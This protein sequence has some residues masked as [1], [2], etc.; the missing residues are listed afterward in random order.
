MLALGL[1]CTVL[2]ACSGCGLWVSSNRA[3]NSGDLRLVDPYDGSRVYP[4]HVALL[5]SE[6]KVAKLAPPLRLLESRMAEDSWQYGVIRAADCGILACY[7]NEMDIAARALD[8]ALELSEA[9]AADESQTSRVRGTGG[10]ER[11]KAFAGEPHETAA[12][13]I[14]RGLVYLAKNDPENAKSCFLQ[15]TLADAMSTQD[16]MRSNWLTADILT[17][18]SFRLYGSDVRADDHIKMIAATYSDTYDDAG[19]V[20]TESLARLGAKGLT[21]VVVCAGSPP[22]KYGQGQLMYEAAESKVASV[23]VEGCP[24]WLTDSVYIQAVTRGRRNVDDMIR[25]RERSRQHLQGIGS[26]GLGVAGAVGGPI[27]LAIQLAAA[28]AIDGSTKID[29]DADSRQ[30][31]AIPGYFYVWVSNTLQPGDT[32]QVELRNIADKAIAQGSFV[33]PATSGERPTIAL[34]WFPR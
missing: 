22:V 3:V 25:A 4:L 28:A 1:C 33:I 11:A 30:V 34:A 2:V 21:I 19:W 16:E 7:A 18:L 9:I 8:R 12:I 6:Q 27:G 15:A 31:G 20:D 24:A 17:T 5:G 26:V 32:V 23:H 10:S 14:F 29:I 13:Y